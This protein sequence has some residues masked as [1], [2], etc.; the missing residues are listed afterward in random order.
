MEGFKKLFEG[1]KA[2]VSIDVINDRGF[3]ENGL[4][5]S[6]DCLYLKSYVSVN[7]LDRLFVAFEVEADV[8]STHP[9]AALHSKLM[10]PS[11]R[12][13]KHSEEVMPDQPKGSTISV[14]RRAIAGLRLPWLR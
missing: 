2:F 12:S 11:S 5:N 1:E 7:T 3:L 9:C 8:F 14:N 6:I 13:L 4:R 10:K